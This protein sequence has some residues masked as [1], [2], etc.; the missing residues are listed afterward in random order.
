M[1]KVIPSTGTDFI[2]KS[3]NNFREAILPKSSEP[4]DSGYYK[5]EK[6]SIERPA[7]MA[8][9]PIQT[10]EVMRQHLDAGNDKIA[11]PSFFDQLYQ[12]KEHS[13]TTFPQPP[14]SVNSPN[15]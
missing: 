12:S 1:L 9:T 2:E 4:V 3:R 6:E 10:G 8:H 13:K 7:Q 5:I 15:F 14:P 11:R